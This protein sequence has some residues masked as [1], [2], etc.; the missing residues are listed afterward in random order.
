MCE[1]IA[2]DHHLDRFSKTVHWVLLVFLWHQVH[3]DASGWNCL[4]RFA[5]ILKKGVSLLVAVN[6]GNVHILQYILY[7]VDVIGGVNQ[8]S[9][10]SALLM[11]PGSLKPVYHC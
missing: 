2:R 3:L 7:T 11:P 10:C 9:A 6:I 8:Y 5:T 1:L 4:W